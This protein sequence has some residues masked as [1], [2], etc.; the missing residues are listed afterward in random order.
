[1]CRLVNVMHL[2]SFEDLAFPFVYILPRDT[3][4]YHYGHPVG[5]SL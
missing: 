4:N 1:M 3:Y 2:Y 5:F